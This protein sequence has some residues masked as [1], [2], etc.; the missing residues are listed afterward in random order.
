MNGGAVSGNSASSRGGGVD[1][2]G[3]GATFTMN[4]GAVSGNSAS[5]GGGVWVA[6]SG[7][8]FTMSGGEVSGNILSGT[9]SYG[10]EVLLTSGTFKISGDARP[11]RVFLYGNSQFITISGPLSGG[12]VPIDL[13]IT[14]GASLAS[15][16]G[17][18]ILQL[19][20]SYGLGDLASLKDH[21]TLG[22]S[23]LTQSP[24]TEAAITG[25]KIDDG[26]YVAAE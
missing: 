14:G 1:V 5:Y 10:R 2:F 3:G 16:A 13:G 22:N 18:Q 20:G 6:G 19:D 9:N 11:E 4:G 23:Q 12:T 21:F 8:T 17:Q 24:Y 25:Y 7:A 26:G 15:W